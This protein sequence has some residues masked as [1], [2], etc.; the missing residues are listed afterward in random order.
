MDECNGNTSGSNRPSKKS[1]GSSKSS[2]RKSSKAKT[3]RPQR[4]AAHNARHMFSQIDET[5][6]DEEDNDSNDESSDSFQDPDDFSEPEREMDVKHDEFKKSQLK[7]FVNASKPP[8]CSESQ[9]NVES[10][11]RLVLKLSLRDSKKSV[12]TED[13]KPTC[14]TEDNMVC[15]S[16]RPQPRECHHKT[17]PD[18]KSL[19]SVLSSMTATNSELP[20]RHN[21]DENDDKIQTEN[22]TNNLDPSRYVEENTDQCRKVETLTYELSRSGDTLLTDAE[23]DDH[24]K[25]NAN[26]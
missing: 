6:T 25:H 7:K 20:Q 1:K 19:D 9:S 22:A 18:S 26:G 23:N 15:Q 13:T 2:K 8:V 21:G 12:P 17:F 14:E 24:L 5:S 16:S 11:P 4:V 3:S 10:R